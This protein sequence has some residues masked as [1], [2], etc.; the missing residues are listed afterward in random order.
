M[1]R[2]FFF[3]FQSKARGLIV[4][5]LERICKEQSIP[6]ERLFKNIKHSLTFELNL[7]R[8]KELDQLRERYLI[9]GNRSLLHLIQITY[10]EHREQ[11][12]VLGYRLNTA[13]NDDLTLSSIQFKDD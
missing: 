2:I 5:E 6:Y 10:V 3:L 12:I 7:S 11:A 13:S 8:L 4:D 1:I 9:M